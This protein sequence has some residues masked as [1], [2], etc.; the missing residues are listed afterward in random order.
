VSEATPEPASAPEPVRAWPFRI[1]PGRAS[2]V[3]LEGEA[4]STVT[5]RVVEVKEL[6]D[7]SSVVTRRS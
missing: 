5:V 4:L 3:A 6:P 7:S 2:R 1:A